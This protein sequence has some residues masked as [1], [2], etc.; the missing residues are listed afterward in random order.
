MASRTRS[1]SEVARPLPGWVRPEDLPVAVVG[2]AAEPARRRWPI[3]LGVA[4]SVAGFVAAVLVLTDDGTSS[5]TSTT[6][7]PVTTAAV[8]TTAAPT[9]V[10]TTAVTAPPTT[11]PALAISVSPADPGSPVVPRRLVVVGTGVT[12]TG[13]VPDRGPAEA[14][15][16]AAAQAL[17]ATKAAGE[18]VLDPRASV[19]EAAVS[20]AGVVTF[21]GYTQDY[22]PEFLALLDTLAALA[23]AV[24]A[25][26]ISVYGFTDNIGS[27]NENVATARRRAEAAVQALVQRG[28]EVSR[29]R[30]VA[31]GPA[32]PIASN[33][34]AEGRLR[35][36]RVEFGVTGLY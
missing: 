32:D 24:P 15:V 9:T 3:L 27:L 33:D 23:K 20:A 35:N 22:T 2:T 36:R 5:V 4:V 19:G 10:A 34:T 31:R 12:L 14:A 13:A 26:R 21:V 17:G 28:V 6:T 18:F 8:S 25:M 1:R 11:V 7:I 29:M 16:A 30:V